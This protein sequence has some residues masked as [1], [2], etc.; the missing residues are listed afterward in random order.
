MRSS[1]ILSRIPGMLAGLEGQVDHTE[2]QQNGCSRGWGQK[3]IVNRTRE[4]K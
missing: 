1:L 3:L 2:W 4:Q